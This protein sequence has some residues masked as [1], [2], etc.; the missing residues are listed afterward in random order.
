[1]RDFITD[2][3]LVHTTT[4]PLVS[5]AFDQCNNT[6]LPYRFFMHIFHVRQ[7]S[8]E[9]IVLIGLN[10]KKKKKTDKIHKM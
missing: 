3:I 5:I 4:D 8:S 6:K 7:S 2:Y 1:M 10:K 9:T